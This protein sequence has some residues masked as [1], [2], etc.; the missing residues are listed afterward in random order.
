MKR[1]RV[2]KKA[3]NQH[4]VL[5]DGALSFRAKGILTHLLGQPA[6]VIQTEKSI[7]EA[8]TEGRAAVRTALQELEKHGYIRREDIVSSAMGS[9]GSHSAPVMQSLFDGLQGTEGARE[10]LDARIERTVDTIHQSIERVIAR[11]NTLREASWPW[12]RYTPLSAKHAKNVEHIGGRLR[13]G[14]EEQDLVLVLEYLAAIDGGK[15]ESRKYYDCVTPFNT[16][17]FERNLAM[18]R[19]WDA[20]GRLRTGSMQASYGHDPEIYERRLKKGTP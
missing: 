13:E 17:N 14:Y 7:T 12:T 3:Q 1:I 18:A 6:E 20:R 5:V 19:E 16:K 10:P 2:L 8:A 4:R 11:L 9:E 15:E